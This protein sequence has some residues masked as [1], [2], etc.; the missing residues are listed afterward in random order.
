MMLQVKQSRE[1]TLSG[2]I[3]SRRIRLPIFCLDILIHSGSRICPYAAMCA[4][5]AAGRRAG[6]GFARAVAEAACAKV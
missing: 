4:C 1:K 2:L 6:R 5:A 3:R